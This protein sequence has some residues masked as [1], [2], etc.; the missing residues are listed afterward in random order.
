[1][2]A[3]E[4]TF[5][6][7]TSYL[8]DDKLYLSTPTT[9]QGLCISAFSL[10]KRFHFPSFQA[11]SFV[12]SIAPQRPLPHTILHLREK[13]EKLITRLTYFTLQLESHPTHY[14]LSSL[15]WTLL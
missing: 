8:S 10:P 2:T 14:R 1:M 4:M 6:R 7:T 9:N 11:N 5:R 13:R 15:S 12:I 3:A